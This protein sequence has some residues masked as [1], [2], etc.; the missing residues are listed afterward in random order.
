MAQTGEVLMEHINRKKTRKGDD[1]IISEIRKTVLPER[2]WRKENS[3]LQTLRKA[4]LSIK[5]TLMSTRDYEISYN[6]E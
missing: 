6:V 5:R 3:R 1:E 2:E 4:F